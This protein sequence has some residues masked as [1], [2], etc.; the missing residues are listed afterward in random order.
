M[1]RLPPRR[2]LTYSV[3]LLALGLTTCTTLVGP[4]PV[5]S[6]SKYESSS[7]YKEARAEI[8]RDAASAG[9]G[10][11]GNVF[12]AGWSSRDMTPSVGAT[13]AG[14]AKRRDGKRSTGVRDRLFA[15]AVAFD[16]GVDR[17]VIIVG[18]M[19]VVP[20]NIAGAVR[21]RLADDPGLTLDDILFNATH[22]HCGPGGFAAGL[23]SKLTGGDYDPEIETMIVDAMTAAAREAFR[24]LS[25]V[26]MA[27]GM[28]QEPRF[29]ENRVRDDGPMDDEL[30]LLSLRGE[31]GREALIVS[32][33]AHPTIFGARM[34]E[35]SRDY[36]GELQDALAAATGAEVV[37][38]SGA[39]GSMGDDR[40]KAE[41]KSESAKIMGRGLAMKAHT[42]L[43]GLFHSGDVDVASFG[44]AVPMTPVQIRPMNTHF[45]ISPWLARR[46]GVEREG[47]L[48]FLQLGDVLF[49]GLPFDFSGETSLVWKAWARERG[50]DLWPTSFSGHYG[51]YLTPDKYYLEQ[52]LHYETREMSWYG[53]DLE[54][55]MT[56]LFQHGVQE[57]EAAETLPKPNAEIAVLP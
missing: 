28:I 9:R 8:E 27:A 14:Y 47:W 31:D 36:P 3:F 10:E 42:R 12:R 18:D 57:L 6:D 49:V 44:L 20:P 35:F 5:Y 30:A 29:I 11:R 52:P 24:S 43:G 39:V 55:Y 33:A 50:L 54:A 21:E 56:D 13:L 45:R 38:L 4:W 1:N 7:Y 16:D 22:T 25:P 15:R 53:P 26:V 48:Q 34:S 46:L 19:L 37:F 32:Y 40:P 51:G 23:A 17:A 2:W 41:S